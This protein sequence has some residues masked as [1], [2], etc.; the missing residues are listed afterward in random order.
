MIRREFEGL[1]RSSD[2][3]KIRWELYELHSSWDAFCNAN[4]YASQDAFGFSRFPYLTGSSFGNTTECMQ[5]DHNATGAE[6]GVRVRTV[7]RGANPPTQF[8]VLLRRHCNQ[9]YSFEQSSEP[10]GIRYAAS[11]L[12]LSKSMYHRMQIFIRSHDSAVEQAMAT[13]D[14]STI[15]EILFGRFGPGFRSFASFRRAMAAIA[16][17]EGGKVPGKVKKRKELKPTPKGS[18][19]SD[20]STP[21]TPIVPPAAPDKEMLDWTT[22]P[23]PAETAKPTRTLP[24]QDDLF[25]EMPAG[26]KAQV[27]ATEQHRV[28]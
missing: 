17:G 1:L 24:Q 7:F 6:P 15:E 13:G 4:W 16:A 25:A 8:Y 28:Y 21:P 2:H 14:W 9:A 11:E 3:P 26:K 19:P 22:P 18:V 5:Q 10:L 23:K 27:I 20:S 12:G